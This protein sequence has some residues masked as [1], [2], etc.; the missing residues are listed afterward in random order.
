MSEG[1]WLLIYDDPDMGVSLFD[2]EQNAREAYKIANERWSVHL[3]PPLAE[4]DNL[5]TQLAQAQERVKE[6]EEDFANLQQD[7]HDLHCVHEK[8]RKELAEVRKER[9]AYRMSDTSDESLSQEWRELFN[10]CEDLE[11]R[12]IQLN[13]QLSAL[14]DR[15]A[16]AP[17]TEAKYVTWDCKKLPVPYPWTQIGTISGNPLNLKPGETR[18]VKL[19][20]VEEGK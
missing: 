19:L 2:D 4:I 6:A 3:F 9:D 17:E 12:N 8:T 11:V 7:M 10:R 5:R 18:R 20:L 14:T 1:N 15:I 16:N 13:N